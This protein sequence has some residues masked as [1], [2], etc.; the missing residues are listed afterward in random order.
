MDLRLAAVAK[1]RQVGIATGQA[2][3]KRLPAQAAVSCPVDAAP[4]LGG[5]S[6]GPGLEGQH[7]GGPGLLGMGHDREAELRR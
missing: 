6:V 4:T 3:G 7:I 5:A 1:D 2:I